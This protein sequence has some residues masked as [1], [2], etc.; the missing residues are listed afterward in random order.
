MKKAVHLLSGCCCVA[1]L[2]AWTGLAQ[3]QP[4]T[5]ADL[6][7]A[8]GDNAEWLMYGRD[9]RNWRYSPLASITP[10]NAAQLRPVWAMSTGGSFPVWRPLRWCAEV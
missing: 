5:T 6:L 8:Q 4:V 2:L 1:A 7:G 3:A 10:A 9:Y